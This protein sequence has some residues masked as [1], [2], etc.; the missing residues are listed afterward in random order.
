MKAHAD[1]C[2]TGSGSWASASTTRSLTC[3]SSPPGTTWTRRAPTIPS[4]HPELSPRERGNSLALK[5]GGID[6][7]FQPKVAGTVEYDEN[8]EPDGVLYDAAAGDIT[9][10]IPDALASWRRRKDAVERLAGR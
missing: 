1:K 9:A 7:N 10:T 2:P 3:P 6:R 8:G 4:S 5:A